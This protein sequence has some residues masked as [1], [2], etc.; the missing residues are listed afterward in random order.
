LSI[1]NKS[2]SSS[3]FDNSFVGVNGTLA[4]S[5]DGTALACEL[6]Q[7]N[8][9][10]TSNPWQQL[11]M[12]TTTGTKMNAPR[13]VHRLCGNGAFSS[14]SSSS[15]S[16]DSSSSA[17]SSS[18]SNA[19]FGELQRNTA[20]TQEAAMVEHK[21]E[22]VAIVWFKHDLR[23]DDH[24]GLAASAQYHRVIPLFIFDSHFY[25]GKL[26]ESFL[27]NQREINYRRIILLLYVNNLF[28]LVLM[29]AQG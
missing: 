29:H 5:G 17:S 15:T 13:C 8:S 27:K 20:T 14:S 25:A 2:S 11:I 1:R 16:L 4:R 19:F 26:S 7:G 18:S 6:M 10:G 28:P 3:F 24:L 22:E 23:M 12:N 9:R 21:K